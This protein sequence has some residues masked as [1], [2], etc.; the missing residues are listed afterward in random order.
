MEDLVVRASR[1]LV[2]KAPEA[3]PPGEAEEEGKT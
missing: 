3:A 1:V 2:A